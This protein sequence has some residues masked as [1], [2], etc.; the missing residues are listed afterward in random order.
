MKFGRGYD[1]GECRE[2]IE[3]TFVEEPVG[4]DGTGSICTVQAMDVDGIGGSISEDVHDLL[5]VEQASSE[6]ETV[7]RDTVFFCL[8]LDFGGEAMKADDGRDTEASEFIEVVFVGHGTDVKG[9][10]VSKIARQGLCVLR[11]WQQDQGKKKNEGCKQISH[12]TGPKRQRFITEQFGAKIKSFLA[13]AYAPAHSHGGRPNE[14]GRRPG[15]SPQIASN[16]QKA[17]MASKRRKCMEKLPRPCVMV[18]S[19]ME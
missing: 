15:K 7:E 16:R 10:D 2:R 4:G 1:A 5:D 8:S 17:Q 14:I 19:F 11:E 6:R 12:R 13:V 9:I 18:R 3:V